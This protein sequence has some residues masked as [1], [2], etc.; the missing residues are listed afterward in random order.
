MLPDLRTA[1]GR[2]GWAFI[3]ILGGC[4]TFTIFAAVGVYLVRDIPGFAFWLA[5][6]A[7]V[8]ILVGMTALSAMLVKRTVKAGRDGVEVTDHGQEND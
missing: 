8:Q 7:H 1:E 5:L 3:A 2:R 4:I 6:A